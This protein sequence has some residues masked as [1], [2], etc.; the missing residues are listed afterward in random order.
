MHTRI[1][2]IQSYLL[3]ND[4]SLAVRRILDASLDTANILL[5]KKSI[6]FSQAYRQ[7]E[8]TAIPATFFESANNLLN[9]INDANEKLTYYTSPLVNKL[10]RRWYS[11][12][13]E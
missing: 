11:L 7:Y 2:E 13:Q 6:A 1:A 5:L 10:Y 4:L 3:H 9:K 12:P 8:K